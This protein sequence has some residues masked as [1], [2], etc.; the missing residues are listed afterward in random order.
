MG[1]VMQALGLEKGSRLE[2]A[3]TALSK[4]QREHEDIKAELSTLLSALDDA[5]TQEQWDVANTALEAA[6]KKHERRLGFLGRALELAEQELA[7]AEREAK[8]AEL[9]SAHR[10]AVEAFSDETTKADALARA[11]AATLRAK[12]A[13][14]EAVQ[15]AETARA[16]ACKRAA[17]LG[18]PVPALPTYDAAALA[19]A[20]TKKTLF[21]LRPPRVLLPAQWLEVPAALANVIYE[22]RAALALPACVDPD[23]ALE[24][25]L[26]E[27]LAGGYAER[28]ADLGRAQIAP[29]KARATLLDRAHAMLAAPIRPVAPRGGGEA[30]EEQR[31]RTSGIT[32]EDVARM[33]DQLEREQVAT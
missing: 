30:P 25:Q 32:S 1:K 28:L 3:K 13:L 24:D 21:E 33:A 31:M 23:Y 4:L 6:E 12:Q 22:V 16:Q 29:L 17:E 7:V 10:E 15:R 5:T 19:Y 18:E 9:A 26:R 27:L 20:Q 8:M 14:D 11:V 2:K